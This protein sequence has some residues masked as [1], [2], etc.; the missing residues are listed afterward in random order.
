MAD[1][2]VLITLAG[3]APSSELLQWRVEEA[4]LSIAVDGGWLAHQHAGV[5]PD[6]ILG[7]FD[8]SGDLSEVD[9]I[10]PHSVLHELKD[11]NHTDFEKTLDWIKARGLPKKIVV[12]GGLGKRMDHTLSNL[13]I[14]GRLDS[15]IEI[16]FDDVHEFV[17]R[18]TVG[19]GRS[20][21]GHKGSI[22]SLLPMGECQGVKSSGLAW[23]LDNMN[24]SWDKMI[25][26][27]NRCS[28]DEVKVS[29]ESGVL[30]AFVSK[31]T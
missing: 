5:A 1:S 26:Q 19:V 30:Y 9:K 13:M 17:C 31:K 6:M 29:C 27:S 22:L 2:N 10:F 24:F 14:A 15:A 16:V 4:D 21:L 7:D 23:E 25:S 28:C 3:H 8:S 20:L 18:I 11:Q 12:L